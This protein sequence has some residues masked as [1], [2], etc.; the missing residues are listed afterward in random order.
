MPPFGG[1][2]RRG[3]PSQVPADRLH[4]GLNI[5]LANGELV[6]RPGLTQVGGTQEAACITGMFDIP[7]ESTAIYIAELA[8]GGVDTAGV[9]IATP[10]QIMNF[11]E[12]KV[13][14]PDLNFWDGSVLPTKAIPEPWRIP[15]QTGALA[16]NCI[17]SLQRLNG[18]LITHDGAKFYEVTFSEDPPTATGTTSQLGFLLNTPR[19]DAGFIFDASTVLGSSKVQ[20]MA[21]RPERTVDQQNADDEVFEVLYIG[22]QDGKIARWDGRTVELVHTSTAGGKMDIISWNLTGLVAAGDLGF[23]YQELIGDSWTEVTWPTGLGQG[24]ANFHCNGLTEWVGEVVLAGDWDNEFGGGIYG[25]YLIRWTIAGGFNTIFVYPG[26]GSS[27]MRSPFTAPGLFG[28]R[29]CVVSYEFVNGATKPPPES[30]RVDIKTYTDTFAGG[31]N[32]QIVD[33]TLDKEHDTGFVIPYAGGLMAFC[34]SGVSLTPDADR[35]YTFRTDG[36]GPITTLFDF[37]GGTDGQPVLDGS[38]YEAI[39]L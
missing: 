17:K 34:R 4:L 13:P 12:D 1:M 24:G 37:G 38:G 9:K 16:G 32:R 21:T 22:A 3:D 7:D 8:N 30:S 27:R 36:G 11:N 2:Y 5:R 6:S 39:S 31:G 25:A 20:S 23:A 10:F 15:V 14:P 19:E 28:A 18:R 29:L 33:D 35:I 26:A